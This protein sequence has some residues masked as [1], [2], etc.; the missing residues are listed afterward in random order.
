VSL[1]L[2]PAAPG[3]LSHWT[4][5]NGWPPCADGK[6]GYNLP[7]RPGQGSV[8]SHTPARRPDSNSLRQL[9]T[10]PMG[11]Q[12]LLAVLSGWLWRINSTG[13]Y[14]PIIQQRAGS[15]RRPGRASAATV[16]DQHQCKSSR[17]RMR[18]CSRVSASIPSVNSRNMRS[19]V[20]PA[21]VFAIQFAPREPVL[22]PTGRATSG[23][24][25]ELQR[26]AVPSA[27]RQ[28]RFKRF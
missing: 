26:N 13:R 16:E 2:P 19:R 23:H 25:G 24:T 5:N 3:G 1:S 28:S 15:C 20:R 12:F 11:V 10:L 6:R 7:P 8:A 14:V 4:M 9:L 21:P 27:P 22:R 17:M 18:G